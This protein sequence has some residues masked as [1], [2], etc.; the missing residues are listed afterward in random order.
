MAHTIFIPDP[1][2]STK[3]A[4]ETEDEQYPSKVWKRPWLTPPKTKGK[5]LDVVNSAVVT[6]KGFKS[7][8]PLQAALMALTEAKQTG[9]DQIRVKSPHQ[10]GRSALKAT[11][12]KVYNVSELLPLVRGTLAAPTV[13]R[14]TVDVKQEGSDSPLGGRWRISDSG[15]LHKTV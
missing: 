3:F 11:A 15:T 5:V 4:Q 12:D 14:N 10:Y 13:G 1:H 9:C 6:L 8:L 2:G 7:F